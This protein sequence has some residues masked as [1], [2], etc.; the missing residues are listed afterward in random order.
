M[1]DFD[2]DSFGTDLRPDIDEAEEETRF[3]FPGV[4][5]MDDGLVAL[6]QSTARRSGETTVASF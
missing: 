3:G 1:A 5:H 4:T 6:Q 2:L